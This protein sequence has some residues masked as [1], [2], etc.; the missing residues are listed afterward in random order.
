MHCTR[1]YCMDWVLKLNPDILQ[2]CESLLR[3]PAL[4]QQW[5]I[6]RLLIL[7]RL[8]CSCPDKDCQPLKFLKY[9]PCKNFKG[10]NMNIKIQ[11]PHFIKI[12]EDFSY[13]FESKKILRPSKQYLS[14]CSSK[15]LADTLLFSLG[16]AHWFCVMKE[17]HCWGW[18]DILFPN[19]VK[20]W[21]GRNCL[22]FPDIVKSLK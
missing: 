22:L 4:P 20:S 11:N 16:I 18:L 6:P 1:L 15:N 3:K 14:F 17:L 12:K 7:Y 2:T 19:V 8:C 21:F 10:R 9:I 13:K 5:K